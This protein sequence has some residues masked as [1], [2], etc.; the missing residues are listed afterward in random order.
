MSNFLNQNL[1][2]EMKNS[3]NST[4]LKVGMTCFTEN[5]FIE[6]ITILFCI[7]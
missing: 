3:Y 5:I 4:F 7:L 2:K 6:V 1:P